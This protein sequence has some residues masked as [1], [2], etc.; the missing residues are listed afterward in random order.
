MKRTLTAAVAAVL[1]SL[2]L[3]FTASAMGS[4][5]PLPE[6]PLMQAAEKGQTETVKGLIAKGADVNS[7]HKDGLTA[8]MWPAG[9]GHTETVK[10]LLE[11]EADVNAAA[12]FGG[13]P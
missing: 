10:A 5:P 7:K 3:P 11:A 1:L 13:P 6:T 4:R 12:E 9:R 2:L 8:L